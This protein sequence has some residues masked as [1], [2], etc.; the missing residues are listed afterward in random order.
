MVSR[1]VAKIKFEITA[2]YMD[3]FK[4]QSLIFKLFIELAVV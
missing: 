3:P 2:R 1:K 4:K